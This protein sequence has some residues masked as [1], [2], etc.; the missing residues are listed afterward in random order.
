VVCTPAAVV[1]FV[2][3]SVF[4]FVLVQT[5]ATLGCGGFG[6][7]GL[8]NCGGFGTLSDC[9]TPG[10]FGGWGDCGIFGGCGACGACGGERV[11]RLPS[12]SCPSIR[13]FPRSCTCIGGAC[14]G[15]PPGIAGL[16]GG[17]G[18]AGGMG[19]TMASFF[20]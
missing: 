4:S 10:I 16:P 20:K 11:K 5:S 7:G 9:G 2:R 15:V 14:G 19:I 13:L 6:N 1:T 12:T 8:G 18:D 3:T 17:A